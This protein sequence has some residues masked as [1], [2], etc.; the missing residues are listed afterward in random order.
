MGDTPVLHPGDEAQIIALAKRA[1][2]TYGKLDIAVNSAGLPMI[3]MIGGHA[4]RVE[5][6]AD[7][8]VA[9][10]EGFALI[11]SGEA[12]EELCDGGDICLRQLDAHLVTGHHADRSR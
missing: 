4:E 3:G 1:T 7:P 11:R 12:F 6:P 8:V 10:S 9:T 2:D 5:R